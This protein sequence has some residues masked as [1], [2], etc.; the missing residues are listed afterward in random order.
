[1]KINFVSLTG[2][3]PLELSTIV[4]NNLD[5]QSGI[6]ITN[7][8]D[9]QQ[10]LFY[11]FKLFNTNLVY[12]NWLDWIHKISQ[13]M[14]SGYQLIKD[15]NNKHK[16]DIISKSDI[17][18]FNGLYP[19]LMHIPHNYIGNISTLAFYDIFRIFCNRRDNDT[20]SKDYSRNVYSRLKTSINEE[21]NLKNMSLFEL[22]QY[23]KELIKFNNT[24]QVSLKKTNLKEPIVIKNYQDTMLDI[25]LEQYYSTK[26]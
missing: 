8:D 14:N 13:S 11:Y 2:K 21:F 12:V 15:L 7:K 24:D 5:Y 22:M 19:L 16:D 20:I 26:Q 4:N 23:S 1:M 18:C 10:V 25:I 6:L 9:K 17:H 3:A